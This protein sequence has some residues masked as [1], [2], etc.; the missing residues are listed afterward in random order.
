MVQITDEQD[1][2]EWDEESSVWS[3]DA[4]TISTDGD[5]GGAGGNYQVGASGNVA[6]AGGIGGRDL[7]TSQTRQADDTQQADAGYYHINI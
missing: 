5:V 4:Y 7:Y 1:E 6:V 2:E 3:D